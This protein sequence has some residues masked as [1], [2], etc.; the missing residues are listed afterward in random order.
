M[1]LIFILT[2]SLLLFSCGS[3]S[4][5]GKWNDQD[6]SEALKDVKEYA[7][8]LETVGSAKDKCYDCYIDSL[9][10]IYDNYEDSKKMNEDDQLSILMDCAIQYIQ[11]D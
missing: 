8:A 1:K 2:T 3:A 5:K 9:E 6:R 4:T 7:A 11:Y 10:K